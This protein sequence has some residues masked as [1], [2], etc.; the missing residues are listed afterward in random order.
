M[1]RLGIVGIIVTALL[2][3]I[4]WANRATDPLPSDARADLIVVEKGKR[5]L[6]LY[7]SGAVLRSYHVALGRGLS[8]AKVREG[9][10]RTP[11]GRY[12]DL[13]PFPVATEL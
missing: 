6:T 1:K 12:T 11:E 3:G 13:L 2:A 9:D 10:N 5:L 7:K 4:V 8:G